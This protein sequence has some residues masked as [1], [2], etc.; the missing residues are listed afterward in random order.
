MWCPHLH[1]HSLART[2]HSLDSPAVEVEDSE[3]QGGLPLHRLSGFCGAQR[4]SAGSAGQ[5]GHLQGVGW[6]DSPQEPVQAAGQS[7]GAR[8]GGRAE[9]RQRAGRKEG[10]VLRVLQAF[11]LLSYTQRPPQTLNCTQALCTKPPMWP[12]TQWL[13]TLVG[14]GWG[15]EGSTPLPISELCSRTDFHPGFKV[16]LRGMAVG[17]RHTPPHSG[18]PGI[19]FGTPNPGGASSSEQPQHPTS[20][21]S[22]TPDPVRLSSFRFR[23]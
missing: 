10:T 16:E 2:W 20:S 22:P 5:R 18:S 19:L 23:S 12:H 6:S 15:T 13:G 8:E 21:A 11:P 3:A 1:P 17:H 4:G 7:Q 9:P 14:Q